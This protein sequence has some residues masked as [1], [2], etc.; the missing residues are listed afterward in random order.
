[1]LNISSHFAQ[2]AAQDLVHSVVG[3][4]VGGGFRAISAALAAVFS[5]L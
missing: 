4:A 3:L 1:M 2:A 5:S